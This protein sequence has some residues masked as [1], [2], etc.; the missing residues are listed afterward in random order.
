MTVKTDNRHI[1][2]ECQSIGKMNP[3]GEESQRLPA[4][5]QK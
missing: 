4:D 2:V 5:P 3:P 1:K